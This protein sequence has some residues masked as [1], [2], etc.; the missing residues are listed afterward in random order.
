MYYDRTDLSEV[1]DL[2]KSDNSKEC[3]ISQ[4]SVFNVC[5]TLAMLCLNLSSISIT[6][7]KGVEYCCIIQDISKS[8]GI[9]L[10][11]VIVGIH[12]IHVKEVNIKNRVYNYYFEHLVKTKK[13]ESKN[14]LIHEKKFKNLVI[15]F[16]DM[17]SLLIKKC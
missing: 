6:N 5:L 17:F 4:G 3:I 12:K 14:I 11:L 7:V 16:I 2:A 8:E 9:H 10:L 15:Y 13:L 1:T